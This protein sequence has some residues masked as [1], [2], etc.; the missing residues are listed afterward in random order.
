MTHQHADTSATLTP[1][2]ARRPERVGIVGGGILGMTLALRLV[3]KGH[4]VTLFEAAESLGGLASEWEVGGVTWDKHYHVI[5]LSDT[6]LLAL[7]KQLGLESEAI[8]G[9]TRTGFYTDGRLHS[10]SNSLEFLRFPP[11]GLFDKLR[12]GGTIFYASRVKNWRKLESITAESW[13]RKLSGPRVFEKIWRPLLRSKLGENDR[14]ASAAFIWAIIARMYA[15]RRTGLKKEMFGYVRGGYATILRRF[16]DL[17]IERGVEIRLGTRVDEVT[18]ID[19]RLVVRRDGAEAEEFD[20]VVV[21]LPAP[22]A[23][24]ICRGLSDDEQARLRAIRYQGIVCAS[25][26][27]TRPLAGFYV[28]NITETSFPFTAVIETSALVDR[29]QFGG[30]TLVYLPKYVRPDDP[31]FESSDA[32]IESSFL[33]GLTR[34][35]PDLRPEEVSA[36]K[37]SRVR[38]VLALSTLDYSENLSPM[39]TGV[40]GLSIVNSAHIVNGTLNVNE[41]IQ[42]AERA[43]EILDHDGRSAG[44]ARFSTDRHGCRV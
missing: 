22:M 17:L 42:L 31:I 15:A 29:T 16:S 1:S 30:R 5:L 43:A 3:E 36:F 34:I 7:L 28:T 9:E 44:G 38:N 11:L 18:R 41:T 10:M 12:L 14:L 23:A 8:W 20:K 13:L 4:E 6:R 39:I 25:V 33:G 40:P 32:E 37:V 24:R 27:L 26:L 35:Y 19:D 21:T 2:E